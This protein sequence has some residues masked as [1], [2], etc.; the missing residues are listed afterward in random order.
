MHPGCP[1]LWCCRAITASTGAA[2]CTSAA[3]RRAKT[4]CITQGVSD[5]VHV[6]A[7]ARGALDARS[8]AARSRVC[9]RALTHEVCPAPHAR[10]HRGGSRSAD[11][12]ALAGLVPQAAATAVFLGGL[13]SGDS[14][15]RTS[16]A[17]LQAVL[18]ADESRQLR[19]ARHKLP[20]RDQCV[21]RTPRAPNSAARRGRVRV[22]THVH[23][24]AR[25]CLSPS[26]NDTRRQRARAHAHTHTRTHTHTQV[27]HTHTHTVSH[28]FAAR[29]NSLAARM[30]ELERQ[31]QQLRA[32]EVAAGAAVA[33]LESPLYSY[34]I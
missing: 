13:E 24:V 28:S 26:M 21:P 16:V 7:L 31:A 3:P 11:R 2:W 5:R 32:A 30:N 8:G 10:R 14:D 29:L 27:T 22:H 6:R 19:S 4:W 20:P 12:G 18:Q 33:L 25:L 34:F 17:R 1:R 9:M 15:L 23:H